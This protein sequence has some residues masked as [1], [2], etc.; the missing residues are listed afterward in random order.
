M[1][2]AASRSGSVGG[3]LEQI[4]LHEL[5]DEQVDAQASMLR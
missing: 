1:R 3:A 4:A 5:A 2:A